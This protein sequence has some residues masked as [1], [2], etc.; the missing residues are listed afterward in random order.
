MLSNSAAGIVHRFWLMCR[1]AN[2]ELKFEEAADLV[3]ASPK[4]L[5]KLLDLMKKVNGEKEI[6][7]DE[8]PI[9]DPTQTA[10]NES[11]GET[12]SAT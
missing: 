8:Q 5:P 12:S 6:P 11:N 7:E 3:P 9:P 10:M 2:P 1:H 4:V